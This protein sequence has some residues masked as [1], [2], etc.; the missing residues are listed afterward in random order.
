MVWVRNVL[1]GGF[2]GLVALF[3]AFSIRSLVRSGEIL[4]GVSVSGVG[5]GGMG[6]AATEQ[7][8][9]GLEDELVTSPVV[10]L[11]NGTRFQLDPL[12]VGFE[13]Q[14]EGILRAA[15]ATGRRSGLSEFADW[16]TRRKY[17]LDPVGTI[18]VA[19]VETLIGEWEQA[20]E[21]ELPFNGSVTIVDGALVAVPVRP[22][23]EVDRPSALEEIMLALL[24]RDVRVATLPLVEAAPLMS[25]SDVDAALTTATELLTGSIVLESEDPPLR[26]RFKTRDLAAALTSV[27]R[28]EPEP[29]I[30][31]GFDTDEIAAQ[32]APLVAQLEAPPRDAVISISENDQVVITPG[33]P[34]TLVDADLIAAELMVAAYLPNRTAP[35]PLATGVDPEFT[36]DDARALGLDG[37]VSEFTTFH[38]CCQPRVTNIRRMAD[39]TSGTIVM[40]GDEF[41]L[42][43]HIGFRTEE[44][45]F[46]EAPMIL[47]GE[48]VPAVGGGVSQF[49]TTLFNAVFLGGYEDVYHQPHSY[50]FSRYPEGREA[51][52]S[53]PNP[54]LIF[55]NDT[56]SA[57]L[58]YTEYTDESIT[59]KIFGDNEGRVIENSLSPRRTFRGPLTEYEA[60]SGLTPG[61][62]IVKQSGRTGWTITLF[63]TITYS[64]GTEKAEEWDW[65]YRPQPRIVRVHPCDVPYSD[66]ACPTT[67]LPPETTT[68]TTIP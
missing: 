56:R 36:T 13:L 17:R 49:A 16:V 8:L 25:D 35:L 58:L 9:L 50:Y 43:E 48:F 67:T 37:L 52:V 32:I 15:F 39:L 30:D 3:T 45:G 26:V 65:T 62:E 5:L 28:T 24:D 38:S 11:V 46:V 54:E 6:R 44:N 57:M 63:R 64:D 22:G 53:F 60:D 55:R 42:N 68:T 14:R 1:I 59:V 27:F 12:Q 18:D 33:R 29:G 20:A 4:P 31:I 2:I 7:A 19:A 21:V 40:P 10:V 34:G 66:I 47:R 23:F 41:S 51:T 61:D